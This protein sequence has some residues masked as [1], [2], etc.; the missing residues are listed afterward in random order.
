MTCRDW[1]HMGK[2]VTVFMACCNGRLYILLTTMT[3]DHET[4]RRLMLAAESRGIIKD[5]Q[6]EIARM[7]GSHVATV[8][9]W[10][11]RG[12]SSAA[13]IDLARKLRV[14]AGWLMAVEGSP[15]P[16]FE[17]YA[18]QRGNVASQVEERRGSYGLTMDEQTLVDG[19]RVWETWAQRSMLVLAR[20]ALSEHGRRATNGMKETGTD[21]S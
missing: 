18:A 21:D 12:V 8:S 14:D 13:A 15:L 4:F 1:L 16:D 7:I 11:K 17:T 2:S 5:T 10:R 9:N 20:S 19:F 3:S 6:T